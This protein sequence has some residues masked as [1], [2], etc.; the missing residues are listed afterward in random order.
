MRGMGEDDKQRLR[1][2]DLNEL[3]RYTMWSVFRVADRSALD[4]SRE[5]AGEERASAVAL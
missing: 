3:I 5:L 1:A 4:G 2:R